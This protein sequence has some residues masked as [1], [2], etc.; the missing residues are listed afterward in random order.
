VSTPADVRVRDVIVIETDSLNRMSI[1]IEDPQGGGHGYRLAG[2]KY[3]GCHP[4]EPRV[5]RVLTERDVAE[6]RGYLAK[7]DEI[8]AAASADPSIPRSASSP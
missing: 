1:G 3:C 8:Q 4:G 2:P 6:I 5:R 7:W